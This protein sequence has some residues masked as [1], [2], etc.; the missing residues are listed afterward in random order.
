MTPQQ[1]AQKDC[2]VTRQTWIGCPLNLVPK[3]QRRLT[4]RVWY[5]V[6]HL[7]KWLD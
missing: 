6:K 5:A 4:A 3:R 2:A 1:Q 7:R